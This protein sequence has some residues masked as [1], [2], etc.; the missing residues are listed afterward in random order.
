MIILKNRTDGQLAKWP[1]GEPYN[2]RE[3]E[4]VS[5][6]TGQE[7]TEMEQA[8]SDEGLLLGD[9]IAKATK[10]IGFSPCPGCQRRQDWLNEWNRRGKQFVKELVRKLG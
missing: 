2:G 8:F 3:W 4:A 1:E 6:T 9:A 5:S 7:L 10:S